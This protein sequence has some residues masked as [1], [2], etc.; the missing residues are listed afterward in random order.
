[1]PDLKV[2]LMTGTGQGIGRGCAIKIANAGY[3][4]SLMSPSSRWIELAREPGGMNR[5]AR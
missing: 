5:A 4:V 1:M 3:T 2:A